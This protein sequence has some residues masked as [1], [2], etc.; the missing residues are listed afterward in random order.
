MQSYSVCMLTIVSS[1][2]QFSKVTVPVHCMSD[3]ICHFT[4]SQVART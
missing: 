3:S 4:Y 1:E 2:G